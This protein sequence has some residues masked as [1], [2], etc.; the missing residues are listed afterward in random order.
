MTHHD[1]DPCSCEFCDKEFQNRRVL[2]GHIRNLHK[3]TFSCKYC[4]CLL[5][6]QIQYEKHMKEFHIEDFE[7][8]Y[9][10]LITKTAFICRYCYIPQ[11]NQEILKEHILNHKENKEIFYSMKGDTINA[12]ENKVFEGK[13]EQRICD[14]CGKSV[15][16]RKEQ[17]FIYK[18]KLVPSVISL[19]LFYFKRVYLSLFY[20]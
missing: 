18:L 16:I 8:S 4:R 2:Q 11:D 9:D 7:G 17:I 14:V 19:V 1:T 3:V 15:N 20:K 10:T 5:S 12:K 6:G 13:D